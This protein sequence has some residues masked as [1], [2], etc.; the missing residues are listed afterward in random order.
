[1]T[2]GKSNGKQDVFA[3]RSRRCFTKKRP[4]NASWFMYW[5]LNSSKQGIS[6]FIY[7]FVKQIMLRKLSLRERGKNSMARR[8]KSNRLTWNIQKAGSSPFCSSADDISEDKER[9]CI[10]R[11]PCRRELRRSVVRVHHVAVPG[12]VKTNETKEWIEGKG[13]INFFRPRLSPVSD[14]RSLRKANN[15]TRQVLFRKVWLKVL[16]LSRL[17]LAKLSNIGAESEGRIFGEC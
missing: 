9:T 17:A 13:F 3:L 14:K 1:M 10:D 12:V 11:R 15:V 5:K 4:G 6:A 8:W 16:W 7:S 2:L